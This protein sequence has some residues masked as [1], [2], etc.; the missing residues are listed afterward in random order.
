MRYNEVVKQRIDS[1]EGRKEC[2]RRLASV[3][4]VFDNLRYNKKL[5]SF[6]LLRQKKVDTQWQLYCL[7]HNIDKL[8]HHQY[9]M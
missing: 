8:A 3:E 5:G 4:H 7:V 6:T 1:A 2:A 9:A